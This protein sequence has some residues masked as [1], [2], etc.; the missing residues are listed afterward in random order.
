MTVED[1]KAHLRMDAYGAAVELHNFLSKW[2]PWIKN[3]DLWQ[4]YG[5]LI[6]LSTPP[7]A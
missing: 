2:G 3:D 7:R 5:R 6:G 1:E 4:V